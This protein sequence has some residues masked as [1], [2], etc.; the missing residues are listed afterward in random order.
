MRGLL[1][2]SLLLN[3]LLA[4]TI[5]FMTLRLG[6]WKYAF[7]RFWHDETGLYQHRK[8]HFTTTEPRSGAVVMLGDSQTEQCEW[9]ELLHK[10]ALP[11]PVLNRGIVGDQVEGLRG[12]LPEVL[13]HRP[14]KIFLCIG[15]NDLLLDK[16][17]RTIEQGYRDIVRKIRS[18]SK[19]TQ[20]VLISVLP[21]NNEVKRIGISNQQITELNNRIQQ[22]ARDNAV[23]YVDLFTPLLDGTGN[24]NERF[25]TDGIHLNG[26]GYLRWR[27]AI[28]PFLK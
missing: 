17:Y 24:L 25:T 5:G 9:A 14:S 1:I 8:T 6:G 11:Q 2:F 22:I 16:D 15:V 12:R 21:V 4:G 20:L 27:T 26:D 28:E 10:Y 7:Y 13:R 23:P 3:S 18:D 19:S